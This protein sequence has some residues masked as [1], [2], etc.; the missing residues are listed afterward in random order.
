MSHRFVRVAVTSAALTLLLASCG[1]TSSTPD[2]SQ[3]SDTWD[4]EAFLIEDARI[5]AEGLRISDPP[6]VER[7]RFILPSEDEIWVTCLNE[8]GYAFTSGPDGGMVPPK[9]Q[10]PE[11]REDMHRAIYVCTQ[12]FPMDPKFFAPETEERLRWMY[13]YKTTTLLSCL[14]EQGRPYEGAIASEQAYLDSE[15]AWSPYDEVPLDG[16]FEL[17]SAACPQTPPEYWTQPFW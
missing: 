14:A 1:A 12:S 6:E 8:A 16:D 2:S 15:G 11:T 17:L 7:V 13:R 3:D 9:E 4:P 10:P 5:Q